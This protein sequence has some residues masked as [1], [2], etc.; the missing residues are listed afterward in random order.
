MA[1]RESA[2]NFGMG[3]SNLVYAEDK[4]H[5]GVKKGDRELSFC[6]FQIHEPAHGER[7]R[8]L[9]LDYKNSVEDCVQMAYLIYKDSG[10]YPWTEYHKMLAMR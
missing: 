4:P 7:A 2:G 6:F 3:Q 1:R 8:R 5:W 9:G 10:F